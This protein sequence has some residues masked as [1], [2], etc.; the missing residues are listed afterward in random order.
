MIKVPHAIASLPPSPGAGGANA[1]AHEVARIWASISWIKTVSNLIVTKGEDAL[2]V[3]SSTDKGK[4][5]EAAEALGIDSEALIALSESL[6]KA[7]DQ[8]APAPAPK[9]IAKK[10]SS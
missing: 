8:P 5:K 3:F 9:K 2:S 7:M 6:I 10:N 4:F 1:P